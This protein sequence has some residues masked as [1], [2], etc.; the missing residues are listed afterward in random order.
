MLLEI[1][2]VLFVCWVSN[3]FRKKCYK[4]LILVLELKFA[5]SVGWEKL[6]NLVLMCLVSPR[7]VALPSFVVLVTVV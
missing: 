2:F 1:F 5:C 7:F 4:V 6:E 3:D